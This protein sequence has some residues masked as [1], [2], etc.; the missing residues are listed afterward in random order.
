MAIVGALIGSFFGMLEDRISKEKKGII[1]GR[2]HC[3]KCEKTLQPRNLI[4]ILTYLLQKG[5]CE[6]CHEKMSKKYLIIE[7]VTTAVFAIAALIMIEIPQTYSIF[8]IISA[9][10]EAWALLPIIA[11]L[12]FLAYYDAIHQ[13]VVDKVAIPS[14]I[15]AATI[16]SLM[17]QVSW[18]S[19]LLGMLILSS[20]FIIQILFSK[21]KWVG[22]GDT[23]IGA[24]MGAALGL[25]I[26]FI[27]LFV[28]YTIGAI[29]CTPLLLM[30]NKK[31]VVPL[32][33]F[34]TAGTIIAML[35]GEQIASWYFGLI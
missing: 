23:R 34:L 11:S 6:Y 27:A 24:I 7:V 22:G 31:Q 29:L 30:K 12:I 10:T 4:P 13:I 8:E 28:S 20:F 25:K 32:V 16:P 1:A 35:W 14:L 17:G 3:P 9:N 18:Q 21:G 19:S 2:S 15:Y 26:G 5:R 33:P